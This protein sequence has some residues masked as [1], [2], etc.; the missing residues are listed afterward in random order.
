[1]GTRR[2]DVLVVSEMEVSSLVSTV[3]R[4][5]VVL[6]LYQNVSRARYKWEMKQRAANRLPN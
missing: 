5:S 6:T 4:V 2:A 1:M 3:R